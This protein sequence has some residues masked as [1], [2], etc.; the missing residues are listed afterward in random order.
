MMRTPDPTPT[1]ACKP[2]RRVDAALRVRL[3]AALAVALQLA[4]C[5]SLVPDYQR[6]AAP[7]AASFPFDLAAPGMAAADID[8]QQFYQDARLKRLL[9]LALENNRD[10][11]VAVLSISQA[12]AQLQ[13][14]RADELPTVN[15]GATG[16]RQPT[17]NGGS[18]STY[19]VGFNV[20]AYELDFFGRVRDLS[21]AAQAQL[22]G[23]EEA[24]KTV[25]MGLVASVA[26]TYLALLADDELLRVTRDTLATRE[27]SLKLTKLKFDQGVSSALDYRQAESLT[28]GARVSLAQLTRQRALDDNLLT[29]LVAQPLAP[30]LLAALPAGLPLTGQGLLGDLPAGLP[31]ELLAR[32]PDVRQA[33]QQMLAADANIGAARAAFFPRITLTSSIGTASSSLSGLF[34]S[35]S[36]GWAFAPQLLL[37]V[38][39]AGRNQANLDAARVSREIATAQYERAIQGAFREVADALASRATLGEQLR[40]QA[41][42][43]AATEATLR[44]T[45]LRY[46]NGAANYLEVLDAQRSVFAARQAVV[47]LQ[48]LQTQNLV[49]LY[50]VLGG[51]WKD[52]LPIAR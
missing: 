7:V 36:F 37:P 51:G 27:E 34:K 3:L 47:Q 9:A 35:G 12:R 44:L 50:K 16:S 6:P 31:S 26:S 23:T 22:L 10:L 8:W 30:E 1:T 17:I 49:G 21:Q 33:E 13:A 14:K 20:T 28:E 43:A 5:S 18:A 25:Q 40:A 41:A 24:R 45:D 46:R 19:T 42:Q 15:V 39:D 4:G 2:E 48:L 29:L 11:R 32:R 52:A 38:F